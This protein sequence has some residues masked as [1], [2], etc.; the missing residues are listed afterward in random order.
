MFSISFI[1]VIVVYSIYSFGSTAS[2][3]KQRHQN[4]QKTKHVMIVCLIVQLQKFAMETDGRD[5]LWIT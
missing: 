4:K 2:R 1:F 3:I 5:V